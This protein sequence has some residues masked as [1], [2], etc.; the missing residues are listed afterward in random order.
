MSNFGLYINKKI[1]KQHK[2]Q[3]NK[4]LNKKL[5]LKFIA[6]NKANKIQT[7][8]INPRTYIRF[9]EYR[10]PIESSFTEKNF[11]KKTHY[12]WIC[13]W[14]DFRRVTQVVYNTID[15]EYHIYSE[16]IF[17]N[18]MSHDYN[19]SQFNYFIEYLQSLGSKKAID[20]INA[21]HELK[22]KSQNEYNQA[23]QRY[24]MTNF[25]SEKLYIHKISEKTFEYIK[26]EAYYVRCYKLTSESYTK[27]LIK[28][29][30]S[31]KSL[32]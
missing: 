5:N 25:K 23:T 18:E 1:D 31:R 10:L 24:I 12:Q 28:D 29:I 13:D 30:Y 32:E 14:S 4:A 21:L 26:N 9:F 15:Q 6:Y 7:F 19:A 8:F 16:N 3:L 17:P 11:T 2:N 27:E 22:K 20:I